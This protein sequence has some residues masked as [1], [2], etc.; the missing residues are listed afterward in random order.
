M[1]TARF[2]VSPNLDGAFIYREFTAT[3]PK[4]F[5]Q[6]LDR[7][8]EDA[9]LKYDLMLND[10][11]MLEIDVKKNSDVIILAFTIARE[12]EGIYGLLDG[13]IDEEGDFSKVGVDLEKIG[14]DAHKTTKKMIE[15]LFNSQK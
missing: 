14:E 5:F 15:K 11:P 12:P 7:I 10:E 1:I 9:A 13:I 2:L 3:S 8:W 6:E 4:N